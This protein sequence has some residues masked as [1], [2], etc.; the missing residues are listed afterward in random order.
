MKHRPYINV[1][2]VKV[3]IHNYGVWYVLWFHGVSP[4]ALWT[5]FVA[6]QLVKRDQRDWRIA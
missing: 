3:N 1:F 6:Y 5:I 4:Y 2:D